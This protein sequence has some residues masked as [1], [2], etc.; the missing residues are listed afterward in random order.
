VF[1][2]TKRV[3]L[4]VALLTLELLGLPTASGTTKTGLSGV[5]FDPA[6]G[7]LPGASVTVLCLDRAL[8]AQTNG[9]GTFEFTSLPPG[10]Y[11]VWVTA[12]PFVSQS[13]ENVQI[14]EGQTRQ[15]A[16]TMVSL[17]TFDF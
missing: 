9:D 14:I 17:S 7:V 13:I 16:I 11:T 6:G 2:L 4:V 5:V 15:L 8:E 3:A 10:T 12:K 1:T